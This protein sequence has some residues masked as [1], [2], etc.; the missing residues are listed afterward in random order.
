MFFKVYSSTV[1]FQNKGE[2]TDI[3][4][5]TDIQ[6]NLTAYTRSYSQSLITSKKLIY[7]P[8]L[9]YTFVQINVIVKQSINNS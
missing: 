1:N 5:L 3:T 9:F 8:S 4:A 7:N 6:L 2:L